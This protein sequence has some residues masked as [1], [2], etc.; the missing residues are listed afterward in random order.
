MEE[1]VAFHQNAKKEG[2]GLNFEF[3]AQATPQQNGWVECKL[4]C[5][6][7]WYGPVYGQTLQRPVGQI[8]V[9]HHENEECC[10]KEQERTSFPPI[11][12]KDPPFIHMLQAFSKI[13]IIHDA[14]MI[15][16][17]LKNCR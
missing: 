7:I 9:H 5:H 17:E 12:K 11:F 10:C 2:L 6:A 14:K 8:H 3:M 1:N 4:L 15:H 16:G 13:G